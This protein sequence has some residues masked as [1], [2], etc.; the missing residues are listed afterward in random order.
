MDAMERN[1]RDEK[2][3]LYMVIVYPLRFFVVPLR[4][5]RQSF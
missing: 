2:S 5:S 1:G 4:P 3:T